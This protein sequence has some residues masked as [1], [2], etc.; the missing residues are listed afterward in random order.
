MVT[1]QAKAGSVLAVFRSKDLPQLWR[2]V[3]EFV[4]DVHVAAVPV[5]PLPTSPPDHVGVR[6]NLGADALPEDAVVEGPDGGLL[7]LVDE[8]EGCCLAK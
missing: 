7:L 6:W 8:S 5:V 2:R 1:Y 3:T 4:A